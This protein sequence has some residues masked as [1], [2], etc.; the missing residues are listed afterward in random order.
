MFKTSSRTARALALAAVLA[1]PAV[2]L[3]TPAMAG[4][5]AATCA[6]LPAVAAE[7]CRIASARSLLAA[8]APRTAPGSIGRFGTNLLPVSPKEFCY[9][10][11]NCPEDGKLPKGQE[12]GLYTKRQ[13]KNGG[14]KSWGTGPLD[15]QNVN[16]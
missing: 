14:G 3:H 6:S 9:F 7:S 12:P 1:A 11:H 16:K 8:Y 13:C 2:L 5:E 4:G 15:C 10:H